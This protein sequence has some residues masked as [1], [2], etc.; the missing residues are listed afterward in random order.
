[1][2][3]TNPIEPQPTLLERLRAVDDGRI[4]LVYDGRAYPYRYFFALREQHAP[5]L[6]SVR[7]RSIAL[8]YQNSFELASALPLLDGWVS[9]ILL[10]PGDIG[11]GTRQSFYQTLGVEAEVRLSG[12]DFSVSPL[13]NSDAPRTR[14]GCTH[15]IIPTSGT[16]GVPKLIWHNLASLSKTVK[17]DL[18]MGLQFRWGLTYELSRFAGLQVYLQA[19]LSGSTLIIPRNNSL[20][21]MVQEFI[22]ADC[23]AL[24]G[25][26]SFWRKMLM[27]PEARK[28]KFR[29]VTLGGEIATQEL[30]NALC[31][32]YPDAKVLHIYASTEAGVGFSVK[33][34]REGFPKSYLEDGIGKVRMKVNDA[35]CLM[36]KTPGSSQNDRADAH[37]RDE[38]GYI[39]TGDLVEVSGDRILFLGRLSGAI[40]VGGNKVQPEE[41]EKALLQHPDV[42][43]AV[44]Y[45][46]ASSILGSIV[47]ADVVASCSK[48]EQA[49]FR[50]E[51]L[52]YCRARLEAFK[53]PGLLNFVED[54]KM[55]STGK[56]VRD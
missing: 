22:A 14:D 29:L 38:D 9:T 51:L 36:I 40:N 18:D 37:F 39:D 30:L 53:V 56:V 54:L 8:L 2:K 45:G 28:I 17:A 23:N 47:S 48:A 52:G 26:P 27:L 55:N 34:G 35:G 46:K 4:A 10:V 12:E 11:S 19:V 5:V 33:D 16:T 15:W 44:V 3:A 25:T 1:M 42:R 6:E 7:S 43:Q 21:G 41:V 50:K 24:S 13:Q 31:T 20:S 49:A 32:T